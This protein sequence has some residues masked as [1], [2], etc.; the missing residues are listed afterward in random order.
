MVEYLSHIENTETKSYLYNRRHRH[1]QSCFQKLNIFSVHKWLILLQ[2]S[3]PSVF[4]FFNECE[5]FHRLLSSGSCRA[6][7]FKIPKN[8]SGNVQRVRHLRVPSISFWCDETVSSLL[9]NGQLVWLR[10]VMCSSFIPP[11]TSGIF[12]QHERQCSYSVVG[13]RD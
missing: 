12:I 6:V 4:F 11:Q 10:V 5:L 8:I 7:G 9:T 13:Q 3:W 2:F 1:F